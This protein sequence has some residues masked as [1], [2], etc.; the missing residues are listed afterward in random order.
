[1]KRISIIATLILATVA[2]T[3]CSP[4]SGKYPRG[5]KVLMTTIKVKASDDLIAASDI[6]LTYRGKGGVEVTDTITSTNWEKKII[7]DAFPTLTG[8]SNYRL[9]IK[10][11]AKFDKDRCKLELTFSYNNPVAQAAIMPIDIDGIASSKVAAYLEMKGNGMHIYPDRP[12][13]HKIILND[14][15]DFE[16]IHDTLFTK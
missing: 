13:A 6:E 9:L 8:L 2:I 10:P 7:N 1:M 3:A 15:G 4:G 14:K 11:D 5:T 16:M 12:Q